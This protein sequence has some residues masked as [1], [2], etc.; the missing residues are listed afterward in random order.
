MHIINEDYPIPPPESSWRHPNS[1]PSR[2]FSSTPCKKF[3]YPQQQNATTW[4]QPEEPLLISFGH[5]E[6]QDTKNE[7]DIV[8][9]NILSLEL[10]KEDYYRNLDGTVKIDDHDKRVWLLNKRVDKWM[11]EG[12]IIMLQEVTYSFIMKHDFKRG[13]SLNV[14]LHD[15]MQRHGYECHYHFYNYVPK[16]DSESGKIISGNGTC[17]LG[18]ATLVPARQLR[19]VQSK[20]L[21]P[22]VNSEYTV[23]D[24]L[25]LDVLTNRIESMDADH[26]ELPA[27]HE[28]KESL[29]L[30]Y[31]NT[32]PNYADRTVLMLALEP[33]RGPPRRCVVGNVHM[34]CQYRD[35]RVMV[36]IAVKTKK[37]IL[38]WMEG[39]RLDCPLVL[40]GDFNSDP[41]E[42]S[43]AYRCFT[44]TLDGVDALVE[45]NRYISAQE[46]TRSVTNERWMDLMCEQP[47]GLFVSV[48]T[49][50]VTT[51]SVM[52]RSV[53]TVSVMT[54]SVMTVSVM[55][56]MTVSVMTVSVMTVS[57]MT[58]SVMTV[59]VMTV[60]VMTVSVMTVSVKTVSVMTRSVMTVSVMTMSVMTMSV[61][62]MPI[63]NTSVM[64]I[65]VSLCEL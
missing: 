65:S 56:V 57:V 18:L 43:A 28:E 23:G 16:R 38:D 27:L 8:S 63:I 32:T 1:G 17:T 51:V 59:S 44:G 25:A 13:R 47:G 55:S 22:W 52:T 5:T 49:V 12:K 45:E 30:K 29:Q 33:R 4:V 60:S 3:T 61:M 50:S 64:T 34:P 58:V 53:M 40:G 48:M 24:L 37:S 10:T 15:L 46:F 31:R 11:V 39:C 9:Y 6:V 35:P 2:Y 36:R 42:G 14:H 41:T 21:R 19:V 54:V 26:P 7:I 62:A 20:L